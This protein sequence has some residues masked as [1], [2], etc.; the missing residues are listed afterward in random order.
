VVHVREALFRKA[1][2]PGGMAALRLRSLLRWPDGEAGQAREILVR[3]G[4][5]RSMP[6]TLGRVQV[7][8][9]DKAPAVL[10][11]EARLCGPE[12]DPWPLAVSIVPPPAA[13]AGPPRVPAPIAPVLAVRHVDDSLCIRVWTASPPDAGP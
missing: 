3:L 4:S 10:R 5:S 11:A 8:S 1:L 7:T 12:A 6:L 13:P 9:A 2:A